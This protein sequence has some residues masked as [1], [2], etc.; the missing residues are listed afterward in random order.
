MSDSSSLQFL[1]NTFEMKKYIQIIN[2]QLS[3]QTKL[4]SLSTLCSQLEPAFDQGTRNR[5]PILVVPRVISSH[6][7]IRRFRMCVSES[8][9]IS[10]F[11]QWIRPSEFCPRRNRSER[12]TSRISIP[13]AESALVAAAASPCLPPLGCLLY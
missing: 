5:D 12:R 10:R 8:G 4:V 9:L 11:R 2:I 3:R 13:S 6:V 1:I 7:G